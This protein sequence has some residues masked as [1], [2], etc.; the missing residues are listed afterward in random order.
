MSAYSAKR[1]KESEGKGDVSGR[2]IQPPIKCPECSSQ[3]IWKDGRYRNR[4]RYKCSNCFH[5]FVGLEIEFNVTS[6]SITDSHSAEDV[7]DSFVLSSS[8]ELFKSFPF[9]F[10]EYVTSHKSS[11]AEE[12]LNILRPYNRGQ[13]NPL[14]RQI[15]GRQTS[16]LTLQE[17]KGKMLEFAFYLKKNGKKQTT[18]KGHSGNLKNLYNSG[19]TLFDP[20][21]VKETVALKEC[22]NGTKRTLIYTYIN[23]AKFLKIELPEMPDYKQESKL[24]FIPTESELN[25]LIGCAG[26]KLQ[27]YL[28][29]LKETGARSGEISAIKWIDI[30]FQRRIIT[31]NNAEKGSRPRQIEISEKL[32]TML[33]RIPQTQNLV[34][35]K[36]ANKRMRKNF[37]ST[38]ARLAFRTQNRRI[39]S[40]HLHSFR[41]WF[42]CMLYH[43]TKNIMLVKQKLGHRSITSTQVY[44][45][46][47]ETSGKEE[48]V[49]KTATS[50]EEMTKLI[51]QGYEYVTDTR[52][53]EI[54]YKLFRKKKLWHPN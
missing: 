10:G 5:R 1:V 30:D 28:Q 40:I 14:Q 11:N 46:L 47:L 22:S 16:S 48:Y 32:L 13:A 33:K 7:S 29:T 8:K 35:E 31:I 53:G 54:S 49:S 52:I 41:H 9:K 27:P 39:K 19:A 36:N 26:P 25:M 3:K 6:Q 50:I 34:F 24:P 21:S 43:H 12:N 37:H 18:I 2:P 38:R 45:Q 44:V 17:F 20:E 4:Q 51:E 23:F 42:A 15:E